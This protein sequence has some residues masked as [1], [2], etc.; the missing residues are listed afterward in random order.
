MKK[1]TFLLVVLLLGMTCL[2]S[3]TMAEYTFST[4]TNGSL[5]DM[6]T[7]TTNLLSIAGHDDDASAVTSIGFSF[8]FGAL[9]FTQFSV[10]SNGQMR[11]GATAISGTSRDTAVGQSLLI[12]ISGD[13]YTTTVGKIHY[14]LVGSAPNRKLVVEW[15]NVRIP[16][17]TSTTGTFCTFQAW[18]N[19]TTN[20]VNF[21]YGTMYNMG[22]YAITRGVCISTSNVAGSV[23]NVTTITTTPTY[24]A[25]GTSITNSSFALSSSMTNLNSAAQGS[26]RVFT[27]TPPVITLPPNAAT[28]PSP[29]NLATDVSKTPTLTW[30]S[31]GGAPTSYDVYFGTSDSPASIGNQAGT[32]YTPGTLNYSTT[33]YWKIIPRNANGPATGCPVWSFTTMADPTITTFPHSQGFDTATFPPL[34]WNNYGVLKSNGTRT[35][36]AMWSRVTTGTYNATAGAAKVLYNHSALIWGCLELPPVNLPANHSLSFYWR[37]NDSKVAAFDTTFCEISTNGGTSW[38][39]L[40]ALAPAATQAN[41]VMVDVPLNAYAG[42]GR[43][44][45]FRDGTDASNSAWGSFVD[46]LRIAASTNPPNAVVTPTPAIAATGVAIN[47]SLSWSSGGGSP[48]GFYVF[49]GTTA[50]SLTQIADQV[51]TTYTSV[52]NSLFN[53]QYFW[54]VDAYNTFGTTT[55]TEWSY[56]TTTGVAITPSPV[57]ASINQDATNRVLSWAAVSGATGYKV[58]VGTT[59]GGNELVNMTTVATNSYTHTGNWPWSTQLYW[60]V[61]TL[62]GAQEVTGTEWTFTT[63]ANPTLYPPTTQDFA[64]F[65]PTNWTKWSGV[66]A[67]PS[68]LVTTTSGWVADGYGNVG[69]TGAARDNI[70]STGHNYWLVTPPIDLSAKAT[71]NLEFDL[72]LTAYGVTTPAAMTGTDDKF[73]V[74]IS[75]DGSTWTAAN[76][77]RLWDNAGSPYVYNDIAT[78]GEHVTLDLSAYTGTVKL[79]FYGESTVSNAD[80]DLMIDNFQI[81]AAGVPPTAPTTFTPANAATNVAITTNLSWSG[82]SGVPTGYKVY[83]GTDANPTTEVSDQAT[84]TYDAVNNLLFGT[85]Y[86]W[87]VSAYNGFGSTDGSPISFTTT[88]GKAITPTPAN[89]TTNYVSS[90]TT[91]DWADVSGATGYKI[92]VG[93]TVGGTEIANMVACATSD[94]TYSGTWAYGQTYYWTVYTLDSAQEVKG[95]EWNFTIGADPTIIPPYYNTISGTNPLNGWIV[96][97]TSGVNNLWSVTS[98]NN[99]LGGS[100]EITCT[101]QDIN[102]GTT[103][104]VTP[105]VNT[106]GITNMI[107]KFR[108]MYN[109]FANGVDIKLQISPDM[110]TWTDVWSLTPTTDVAANEVTATISSGLGGTVYL[111]WTLNGNL[112]NTDG[113]YIDKIKMLLPNTEIDQTAAVGGSITLALPA[114]TNTTTSTPL[115]ATVGIT[116][117]TNPT[118]TVTV[119]VGYASSN[120]T[121]PNSGLNITL[122]GATFGGSVVTVTHNLGFIPTQLAYRVLPGSWTV[123]YANAAWT[124]TTATFTVSGKANGD[125]V[126]VFPQAEGQT[127]PV[128]MSS[129]TAVLTNELFVQLNWVVQSETDNMGYNVL[130]SYDRELENSIMVNSELISSGVSNGTEVTYKFT[131]QEVE[132]NTD[133]YYWLEN[134]AINGETEY[135]GPVVLTVSEPDDE[136]PIPVIPVV[137][138]LLDAYPNPFNPITNLQYTV[139]AAGAVTMDVYNVKGQLIKSF[140]AN[141]AKAGHFRF[142]WDGKDTNGREVSS[143]V[144]FYRM[145]SGNYT[146]S[147]KMIMMK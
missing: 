1:F 86:Y 117:L 6:S 36:D 45:R 39:V 129:F 51:G 104:L 22:T 127:L 28:T 145:T 80:N 106:A 10:N 49:R 46:E 40:A 82:S 32:S 100:P 132:V 77:L 54:R 9:S 12:P 142:V 64:T 20:V 59:S 26:R 118:A 95:T 92:K 93:T 41:Y 3:Q 18:L 138:A 126:V 14:K 60:T 68:T 33:Y 125:V 94:W 31:G 102:P 30:A 105:P 5:E 91:L 70:Y 16:Y 17:S 2:F 78:A 79:A 90:L 116:G 120:V 8:A 101:F 69:S 61:Y 74:V 56:T 4:A 27:F 103:R 38:T 111:A 42:S 130:R 112:Y 89:N 140:A 84:T 72:I 15:N 87:S 113:W 47:A 48:T 122:G 53:T 139:K 75:T 99:A 44:I 35:A 136:N 144:Y 143:G 71:Y 65:P 19:E 108:H 67:A 115:T 109:W 57:T 146:A 21:V 63:G 13:N 29:A 23:G 135:Y 7:G 119:G 76:T 83:F 141:H 88:D 11:L 81:S 55:G 123:V 134:V 37:D 52:S 121:L 124:T 114:V 147:K 98:T 50:G 34:G 96:Q 73:A 66:L 24:V 137:T 62:N 131:D 128:E 25:T 58:K 133:Y 85:T 97:M 107:V 110:N 43:L